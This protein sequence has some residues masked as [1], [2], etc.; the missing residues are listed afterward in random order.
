M[1]SYYYVPSCVS[2]GLNVTVWQSCCDGMSSTPACPASA[3]PGFCCFNT[4]VSPLQ[5]A[6]MGGISAA[7]TIVNI[8]CIW[9]FAAL[10]FYVKEVAPL[11]NKVSSLR[12]EESTQ[13][14]ILT[15]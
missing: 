4:R 13:I 15:L 9:V 10:M 6:G 12:Q 11:P 5:V 7:L 1:T 2:N 14:L 8:V 3:Y